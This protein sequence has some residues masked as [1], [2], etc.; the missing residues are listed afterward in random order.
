VPKILAAMR[1]NPQGI[2]FGDAMKVAKHY[3]GQPRN[4]GTSH[5]VFG[6]GEPGDPLV[7]LQHGDDGKAK[8]YQVRQLLEAVDKVKK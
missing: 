6:T 5:H 1:N 4:A 8:P 7:N 2:R 3:F